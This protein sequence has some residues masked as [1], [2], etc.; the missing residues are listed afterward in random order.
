M[1]YEEAE[2]PAHPALWFIMMPKVRLSGLRGVYPMVL[3]GVLDGV[4]GVLQRTDDL[5]FS[6]EQGLRLSF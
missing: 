5:L 6:F 4:C 3:D 1:M 2:G